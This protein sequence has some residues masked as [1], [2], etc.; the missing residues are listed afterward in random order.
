MLGKHIVAARFSKSFM[1]RILKV[2]SAMAGARDG[3]EGV[4]I[5]GQKGRGGGGGL[6]S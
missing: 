1:D 2:L 4:G 6:V 3:P 5:G